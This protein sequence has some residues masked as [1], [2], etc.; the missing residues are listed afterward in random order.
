[1]RRAGK[2]LPDIT[3]KLPKTEWPTVDIL[4][5][6]YG[7]HITEAQRLS[8]ESPSRHD[9]SN[10]LNLFSVSGPSECGCVAIPG[11][12]SPNPT[13]IS[14]FL[15]LNRSVGNQ[16]SPGEDASETAETLE[17][18]LAM[19]Y[20]GDKLNI[21]ICD[22]GYFKVGLPGPTS[23]RR[24]NHNPPSH[25]YYCAITTPPNRP[26]PS[27][28]RPIAPPH[29]QRN[30]S[31]P[32]RPTASPPPPHQRNAPPT[33]ARAQKGRARTLAY[34]RTWRTWRRQAT[35]VWP[36]RRCAMQRLL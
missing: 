11:K 1:M 8:F 23:T 17:A 10:K 31:P 35:S 18:C 24:A 29:Q 30:A 20:P 19:D 9:T 26:L 7:R 34:V 25:V 33:S 27:H 5:A 6:H 15:I 28:H 14:N 2:H 16:T 21:W 32:H 13:R 4:I 12:V 3:P 36:C 22:D